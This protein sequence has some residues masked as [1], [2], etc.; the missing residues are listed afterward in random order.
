MPYVT[1]WVNRHDSVKLVLITLAMIPA[2]LVI[3]PNSDSSILFPFV[4]LIGIP[5]CGVV[6]YWLGNWKWICIPLI[7]MLVEIIVAIPIALR[8]PEA[9]ET[10]MS[11]VLEAPFW[12]GLPA[13]LGAGFG[14]ALKRGNT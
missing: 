4:T 10:P 7:A 12:T 6:A 2:M 8:D 1:S 9:L 3:I 13:L 11:I 5:F 14:Y